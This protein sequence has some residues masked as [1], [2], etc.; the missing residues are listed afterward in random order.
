[1]GVDFGD[2]ELIIGRKTDKSEQIYFCPSIRG[3]G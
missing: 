2:Y 3:M 1:V